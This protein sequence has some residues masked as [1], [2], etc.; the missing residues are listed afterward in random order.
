MAPGSRDSGTDPVY[1]Q[2]HVARPEIKY[3]KQPFQLDSRSELLSIDRI[4]SL[5]RRKPPDFKFLYT[6]CQLAFRDF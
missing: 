3:L 5:E 6:D 1:Q 2:G 4:C